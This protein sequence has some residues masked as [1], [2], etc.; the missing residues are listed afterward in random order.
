VD[1]GKFAA[2]IKLKLKLMSARV[3]TTTMLFAMS[4]VI[5]NIELQ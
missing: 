3:S 2:A 5:K 4:Y 1:A